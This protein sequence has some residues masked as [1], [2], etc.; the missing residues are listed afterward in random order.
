MKLLFIT[1]SGSTDP[2]ECDD[3]RLPVSDGG[4]CGIRPGHAEELIAL[5]EGNVTV[6]LAG[7]EIFSRTVC[8]GIALVDRNGVR[9][10]S[11]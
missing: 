4:T 7:R 6:F 3:I 1:P 9:V 5:G 10:I 8:S 11:G 2:V